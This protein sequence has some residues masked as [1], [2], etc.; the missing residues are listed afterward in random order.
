MSVAVPDSQKN[1]IVII[2]DHVNNNQGLLKM[3][4]QYRSVADSKD[5][6][7]EISSSQANDLLVESTPPV[8]SNTKGELVVK[9][10]Q[11]FKTKTQ[12]AASPCL[13]LGDGGDSQEGPGPELQ[14]EEETAVCPM[15]GDAG[16][17]SPAM[18]NSQED[19]GS[20]SPSPRVGFV[21]PIE[22]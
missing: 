17:D 6:L 15:V 9:S 14:E 3:L 1:M 20:R 22:K 4:H 18:A 10:Y 13:A 12:P 5:F 11:R 8:C 21:G 19:Q 16:P 7:Q 2:I